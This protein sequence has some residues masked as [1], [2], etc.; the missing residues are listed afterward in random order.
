METNIFSKDQED[1]LQKVMSSG[2]GIKQ[3]HPR[4]SL[5]MAIEQKIALEKKHISKSVVLGIAAL[6]VVILFLNIFVL[7]KYQDSLE[8]SMNSFSEHTLTN[9]IY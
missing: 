5:F 2:K 1:W 3:V 4:N 6:L 7:S 8:N 9:Q